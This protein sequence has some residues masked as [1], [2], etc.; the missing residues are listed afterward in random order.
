MD[1]F[2]LGGFE[3]NQLS[4]NTCDKSCLLFPF[5][6]ITPVFIKIETSRNFFLRYIGFEI[7]C[8]SV[9]L[10]SVYDEKGINR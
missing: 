4:S 8:L 3:D 7:G 10:L 9:Y 6:R 2:T 5:F 1:Y